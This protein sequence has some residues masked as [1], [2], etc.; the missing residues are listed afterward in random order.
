MLAGSE[1]SRKEK[2]QWQSPDSKGLD[3]DMS[4]TQAH[5]R[6]GC[7][8]I[9]C[10]RTRPAATHTKVCIS[11]PA[12]LWEEFGDEVALMGEQKSPILAKLVRLFLKKRK[13]AKS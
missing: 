7:K 3:P 9:M 10:D 4:S 1:N 12:Q 2:A 8:C 11:I 5:H 6:P 13:E